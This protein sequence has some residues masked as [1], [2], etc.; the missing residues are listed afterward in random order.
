MNDSEEATCTVKGESHKFTLTKEMLAAA[1]SLLEVDILAHQFFGNWKDI[2]GDGKIAM[3]Q[4]ARR[5]GIAAEKANDDLKEESEFSDLK[6]IAGCQETQRILA[7]REGGMY[8]QAYRAT[9]GA[10]PS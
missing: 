1:K 3:G 7:E 4:R 9:I 8:L 5:L 6:I 10:K 2:D